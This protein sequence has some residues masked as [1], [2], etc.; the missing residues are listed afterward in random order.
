M[1]MTERYAASDREIMTKARIYF[2]VLVILALGFAFAI[3]ANLVAQ[4]LT[5]SFF[6]GLVAIAVIVYCVFLL[7]RGNFAAASTIS[8]FSL[9]GILIMALP[10]QLATLGSHLFAQNAATF[11][12]V[13]F[14]AGFF[15]PGRF[16][17]VVL[18]AGSAVCFVLVELWSALGGRIDLKSAS[19]SAAY[20]VPA[21][22]LLVGAGGAILMQRLMRDNTEHL[23]DRIEEA[24]AER[25]KNQE[26]VG[27]V[28]AQLNQSEKLRESATETAATSVEIEQNLVSVGALTKNASSRFAEAER[29]LTKVS[30]GARTLASLVEKQQAAVARSSGAIEEMVASIRSVSATISSRHSAIVGLQHRAHEGRQIV[31]TST[32]AFEEVK[33]LTEGIQSMAGVI[34]GLASQTDLLAMNA[35]IEAAHAGETGKGFAVVASEIHRLADSSNESAGS[36]EKDLEQLTGAIGTA[37]KAVHD[38]D[39]AFEKVDLDVE[40]VAKAMEEIS[41]STG[42]LDEGSAEILAATVQVRDAATGVAESAHSVEGAQGAIGS[43]MREIGRVIVQ[44]DGSMA[45]IGIGARGIR[46]AV[47]TLKDLSTHLQEQIARLEKAAS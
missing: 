3:T 42:E 38:I 15:L 46:A 41:R 33:A 35:A 24:E 20:V 2:P 25:K 22:Q 30:E 16:R 18:G 10:L 1:T 43:E 14:L 17:V 31:E 40:T 19:A 32:H 13:I 27:E 45:E 28:A 6:A 39:G 34:R 12:I 4:G 11:L 5:P 47:D 8:L 29:A 37:V 9:A 23:R 26:L 44:I 7:R 36:I 21:I